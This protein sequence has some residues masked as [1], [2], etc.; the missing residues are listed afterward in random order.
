MDGSMLRP[1]GDVLEF[2]F[3]ERVRRLWFEKDRAFDEEIRACFGIN[4]TAARNG[5]L[6]FWARAAG[7]ALALVVL[8]DQ[9][10]RNIY[11]GTLRAFAADSKARQIAGYAIGRAFDR[12]TPLDRRFFFY[13]PFEHSEDAADQARCVALFQRWADA[14]D[15]TARERALE[16]MTYVRRHQEIIARF[17][18]FPH[19]NVVLGRESTPDEL[20]FLSEPN[21]S[22]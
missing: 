9:F 2:W 17:G 19:R 13:L 10:H 7:S 14:H 3:S 20:A 15:G 11:R 18:R 22:F 1:P 12:R 16:Q 8:L 21:S 4:V 6:D 5:E